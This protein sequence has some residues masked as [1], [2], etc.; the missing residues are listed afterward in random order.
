M[1]RT[2]F[3]NHTIETLLLW[4]G[5]GVSGSFSFLSPFGTKMT[6]WVNCVDC[7]QME[8]TTFI[9]MVSLWSW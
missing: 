6:V 4:A 2:C 3:F 5:P 1:K 8:S 7:T 9:D